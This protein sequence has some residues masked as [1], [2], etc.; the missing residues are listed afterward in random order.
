MRHRK[1]GRKLG[2][3]SA[4]RKAMLRNLVCN[5][6]ATP[7]EESNPRRVTTTI[8]KAKEARR[9]AE[10]VITLGKRGT[11]H[12]RRRA[13]T[14]LQN[15]RIVKRVF[16]E[17]APLYNDR[18][19]GYTRILRLPK[20]RLGDGTDL[21]YFEL[22]SEAVEPAATE[23]VAPKRTAEDQP[24]TGAPQEQPAQQPAPE[25][26]EPQ[27]DAAQDEAEPQADSPKPDEEP[28]S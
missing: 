15:K 13:L 25:A 26:A 17:I 4:H 18:L 8:P 10:R 23:P 9:L 1:K 22:V 14:L 27:E 11:L 5:L 12:A 16:E 20:W 21:C 28:P 19:G 7:A 24:A 6:F 3:T 2:R